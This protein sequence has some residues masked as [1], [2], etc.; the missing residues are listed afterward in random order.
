MDRGTQ[1]HV[2]PRLE[3]VFSRSPVQLELSTLPHQ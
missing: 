1:F 2:A 3:F